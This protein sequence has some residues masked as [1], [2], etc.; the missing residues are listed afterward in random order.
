[1]DIPDRQFS[2]ELVKIIKLIADSHFVAIDL[3][4]SGISSRRKGSGRSRLSLQQVYEDVRK[5]AK[6]YQI[7]QVGLT[8][9]EEDA[10]KGTYGSKVND[11]K[12][13]NMRLDGP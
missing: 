12:A 11:L 7:L 4:F 13:E 6:Q 2:N 8:I 9:L 10:V 3:E 1:M 5:A